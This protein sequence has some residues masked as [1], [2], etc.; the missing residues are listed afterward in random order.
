MVLKIT[1]TRNAKRSNM[2]SQTASIVGRRAT[3]PET[4][5]TMRKDYIRKEDLVL[6]VGQSATL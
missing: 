4:A 5:Q 1:L 2:L 3:L 6:D